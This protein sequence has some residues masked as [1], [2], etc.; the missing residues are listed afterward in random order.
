MPESSW[1][2]PQLQKIGRQEPVR[3]WPGWP[4]PEVK[5]EARTLWSTAEREALTAGFADDNVMRS[6][7]P[8][9]HGP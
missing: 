3:T 2:T 8:A 9:A 7:I 1:A 6:H 5:L 4:S